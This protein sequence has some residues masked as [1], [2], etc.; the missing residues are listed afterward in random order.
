VSVGA[1]FLRW[2]AAS[3]LNLHICNTT[4]DLHVFG[5]EVIDTRYEDVSSKEFPYAD[6]RRPGPSYRH[7]RAIGARSWD[8]S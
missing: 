1:Q 3:V 4:C 7:E 8:C 2:S 6:W 5:S